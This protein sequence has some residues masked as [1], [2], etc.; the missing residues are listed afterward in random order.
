MTRK[1]SFIYLIISI[2][3]AVGVFLYAMMDYVG[4]CPPINRDYCDIVDITIFFTLLII[5]S[6][7]LVK[8]ITRPEVFTAWK[9]FAIIY[10][11][12]AIVLIMAFPKSCGFMCF[13][14]ELA[15]IWFGAIYVIVSLIIIIRKTIKLR[16]EKTEPI[17]KKS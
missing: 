8:L 15:S 14:R 7:F 11:P 2:A 1:Q 5:A 3:A 13:D 12:I 10:I 9:K 17:Q 16:K 4:I 6:V